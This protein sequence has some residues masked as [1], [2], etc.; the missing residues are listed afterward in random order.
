MSVTLTES[1]PIGQCLINVICKRDKYNKLS[2]NQLQ[3]IHY[4]LLLIHVGY[5]PTLV[6]AKCM[7]FYYLMDYSQSNYIS[8]F[9]FYHFADHYWEI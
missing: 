5:Y 1:H 7:P 9:K 8:I 2:Q 6:V 4:L 3:D